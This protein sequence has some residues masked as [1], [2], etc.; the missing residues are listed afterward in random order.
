MTDCKGTGAPIASNILWELIDWKKIEENVY[1]LQ[2][3][4]AKAYKSR[5]YN[6]AKSLQYL[7]TH[8]LSAKLLAI[9]RVTS[10]RGARTSGI[11]GIRWNTPRQ[12]AE[13][14][15]LLNKRGYKPMP[16]KRILIPKK[17]SGKFRP[18][19]IPTMRDR[20]MQSLYLMSLEPIS[21]VITNP[22]SYGFR[23]KR[24]AADAI[25]R[26]F[27]MLRQKGS[28]RHILEAD[29][30]A[31]FDKISH[32][33]ILNNVPMDRKVLKGWLKSG[34]ISEKLYYD[35]AEGTPQGGIISPC[36][37]NIALSGLETAATSMFKAKFHNKAHKIHCCIYADDFVVTGATHAILTE[38]VQPA[39]ND[40]LRERGLKLSE[41]KTTI[42]QIDDG[43]NFLG[44]NIRKYKGKLITKPA[45]ESIKVF[46]R[47]IR[48][49]IKTNK[50]ARTVN[51]LMLLNPKIRGWANYHRHNCASKAFR[52]VD[53][54]IFKSLWKWAKRRHP[55]KSL[56][57]IKD[58]YFR[59]VGFRNWVFSAQNNK[60]EE[61]SHTDLFI[62]T[63]VK[64]RRHIKI[65][66]EA[67]PYEPVYTQYFK[68][69]EKRQ[70]R[71]GYS[72]Q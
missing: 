24:S 60:H 38:Q 70:K 3:R 12:K 32:E 43:F 4:I 26:C 33:W 36:I 34:Y 66:C 22:N 27:E 23:P 56:K 48:S 62:A 55:N 42:S 67:T 51:L 64:I 20:A 49:I 13:A 45:K 59:S 7:L 18:L 68:D 5:K 17:Q 16:L 8:S 72:L 25:S 52:Y 39:I 58:K 47:D 46:L 40:F 61:K 1:R 11:D 65:K 31:C 37:L 6:K 44:I 69:R 50:N 57:W 63:S 2:A 71:M 28:A 10:N 14:I 53:G 21:E 15:N 9:K 35:T 29:I 41:S 19:S 30:E 54:E